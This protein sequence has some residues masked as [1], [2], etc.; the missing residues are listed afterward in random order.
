MLRVDGQRDLQTGILYF[1]RI[2]WGDSPQGKGVE[3]DRVDWQVA[4]KPKWGNLQIAVF[5]QQ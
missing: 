1:F 5:K 2:V 3:P 4:R